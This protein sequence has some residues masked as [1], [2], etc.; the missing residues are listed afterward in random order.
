MEK[1]SAMTM[2]NT[3]IFADFGNTRAKFLI[4][5]KIVSIDN[6]QLS[7]NTLMPLIGNSSLYYS[8]V[9]NKTET[10]IAELCKSKNIDF[11][12]IVDIIADEKI[13][14]YKHIE[15]IGA[16]RVLSMLGAASFYP[17]TLISV[18]CGT[19]NTINLLDKDY[20]VMGGC[21]FPGVLTMFESMGRINPVLKSDIPY[22]QK[23][24]TI[25]VAENTQQALQSGV[26]TAMAG[27]IAYYI[28]K[29]LKERKINVIDVPICITGGGGQYVYNELNGMILNQ[30]ANI[31][32]K[33]NL[34]LYGIKKAVQK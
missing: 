33:E 31:N 20:R 32:F 9:N 21:I 17:P 28:D 15:G 23:S 10:F 27:G 16:D 34:V 24:W 19:C 5:D 25:N 7:A 4:D 22:N 3:Q 29:V 2:N 14:R 30:K 26:L 18:E 12:N 1:V 6:S 8:S 11:I 13:I